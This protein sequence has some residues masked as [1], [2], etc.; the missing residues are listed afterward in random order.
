MAQTFATPGITAVSPPVHILWFAGGGILG[1][2]VP[3]LFTSVLS[4][5]HDL[6]Y[7][8]YFAIA[9]G[10]LGL[11]VRTTNVDLIGFFRRNWAWSLG[12][13]VPISAFVI[14]NV[15]YRDGTPGPTG[16]YL[17]FE[18][19]WRGAAYGVV[20]ALLLTA[21]PGLVALGLLRGNLSGML[22]KAGFVLATMVMVLVITGV[23]HLGYD[24]FREA[25]VREPEIGNVI[26]SAPMLATANPA[27]S[28]LAHAGM[29]VAAVIHSYETDVFLP[30]QVEAP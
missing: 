28:I 8:I 7:L 12:I 1:F 27:G 29:H 4:L 13:G 5:H 16:A 25:G 26:I 17:V 2:L 14:W 22:R 21:F 9:L 11:Y 24:Q 23:Y 30:P 20:D 18:V 3:F 6:Y 19:L 10:F 15:L